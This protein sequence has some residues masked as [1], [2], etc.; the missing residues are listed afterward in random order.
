MIIKRP[1]RKEREKEAQGEGKEE[2]SS[3]NTVRVASKRNARQMK[4]PKRRVRKKSEPE[5]ESI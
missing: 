2:T 1:R 5:R 4:F 3:A